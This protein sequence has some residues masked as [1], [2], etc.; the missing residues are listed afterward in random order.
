[1]TNEYDLIAR[2]TSGDLFGSEKNRMLND[3][4]QAL[5]WHPTDRFDAQELAEITTA[6]LLVEHGL[7][8]TTVISFFKYPRRFSDLTLAESQKLLSISYNN[9][10]DW[11]IQ[12]QADEVLYVFNRSSP[13]RIA[14]S[15]QI[16]R[17]GA[18]NLRSEAFEQVTGARQNPNLPAL[19]DALIRTISFWKRNLAAELDNKVSNDQLSALFNTLIFL[20]A[21]EDNV[22]RT[23][24]K[25]AVLRLRDLMIDSGSLW[26]SSALCDQLKA[27]LQQHISGS[28]PEYVFDPA[29]LTVFNSLSAQTFRCVL[30]DFYHNKYA[31]YVYDFSLMSKHALSRIYEHYVS[32]LRIEDD[33]QMRFLPGLAAE[34]K[35]R[36]FGSVYTPQFVARF[37]ARYL[38]EQ[39]PP[40]GFRRIRTLDPACGS[41]IFLRTLIELQCEPPDDLTTEAIEGCFRNVSGLDRDEN[42]CQATRLSLALLHLVLTDRLPLNLDIKS[43]EILDF[44]AENKEAL[45]NYD[46]VIAN[47]PFVPTPFQEPELR[48]RLAAFMEEHST[49][50][51][52]LYLAFLRIAIDALR[53][54]GFGFFVLPHNFLLAKS[55]GKMRSLL[56]EQC[57][58][59]CLVDLR[60]V[61]VFEATGSYV[62]LVVFQK[63]PRETGVTPPA[64]V[65]KCQDLVGRAL[66]YAIEGRQIET[67]LFSIYEVEQGAFREPEWHILPPV[68][69]GVKSKIKAFPKLSEFLDVRLGFITGA[70]KVF[71]LPAS[72][73][74]KGEREI[75]VPYLPD[76][77]MEAY[78]VPAR[79]DKFVFYPFLDGERLDEVTIRKDFP[80][81]W[82]YLQSHK[83][84]LNSR[85]P[86]KRKSLE[87]WRPERPRSPEDMLRPKI[88]T[89]HLVLVPRFGLDCDGRYAV[90]HAPFLS[91]LE[92]N[93]SSDILRFFLAVLNSS[94]CFWHI[95][96]HSYSYQRGYVR[97][98]TATLAETPVPDPSQVEHATM[99][100]VLRLVDKRLSCEAKD[101]I[102][103]LELEIDELVAGL[104]HLT[105]KERRG[106]GMEK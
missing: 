61:A 57:F 77:E 94:A 12:V 41:G 3:F 75:F 101:L 1:M 76:R 90:S 79:T 30:N 13:P 15:F 83:R 5:G 47:P 73:I 91:A 50:R 22:S 81:T 88:V 21:A 27:A 10:V 31:P 52:D 99:R 89:P 14:N 48:Q 69:A 23:A 84:H 7:E 105:E 9:L 28:I 45:R 42:A 26:A 103:K 25:R 36:G 8:H 97:L 32:V 100:Q 82:D 62:V 16:S 98:E 34:K 37:F 63:K 49:G 87:W 35:E 11:H 106:I 46:A 68:E 86:V 33:P 104:F 85:P 6:H 67:N 17:R 4:A 96:T 72:S 29:R 54:G 64:L 65:V 40:L 102:A 44:V 53:P 19:D 43:T 55:A 80:K 59:R 39:V 18:S 95:S 2:L 58:V 93:A 60:D 56:F 70:D 78:T 51:I 24:P 20:R 74:P 66:Q 71:V 38:R 92:D